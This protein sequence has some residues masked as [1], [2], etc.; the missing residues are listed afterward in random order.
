MLLLEN[1]QSASYNLFS[2]KL[3]D[4]AFLLLEAH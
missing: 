1:K 3:S 4:L 2:L